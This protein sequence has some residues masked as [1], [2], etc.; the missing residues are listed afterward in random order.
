MT[1]TPK[2]TVLIVDDQRIAR[3]GLTTMLETFPDIQVI[4]EADSGEKAIQ[5]VVALVAKERAPS[6]ILMD[7]AMPGLGG[8]EAI[9]Q[10]K[11]EQPKVRIIIFTES[12]QGDRGLAALAA[13]ADGYCLKGCSTDQLVLTIRAVNGGLICLDPIIAKTLLTYKMALKSHDQGK[14][15]E[16]IM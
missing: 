14:A 3:L 11:A 6:I 5:S 13:G 2:I 10:I 16:P 9:K 1:V 15:L 4:G 12:D 7:L 8:I